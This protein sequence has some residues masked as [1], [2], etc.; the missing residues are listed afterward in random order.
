[1][2][3]Q[4]ETPA[5]GRT[6]TD[7]RTPA[8]GPPAPGGRTPAGGRPS[9][10]ERTAAVGRAATNGRAASQTRASR[11]VDAAER[12]SP[13][14]STEPG[15]LDHYLPGFRAH[16]GLERSRSD[17]T[18]RA[19]TTDIA[20]LSRWMHGTG[21]DDIDLLDRDALRGWLADP[22]SYTHL[23]LPTILRV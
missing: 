15:P 11:S 6:L 20:D 7:G 1:M 17:N 2:A 4:D 19:Y 18:V 5:D 23:T 10:I 9:A 14:T 12:T 3:G 8:G 16:L 21:I 22:V 13:A